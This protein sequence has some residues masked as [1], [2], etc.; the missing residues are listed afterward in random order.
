MPNN[1]DY[2]GSARAAKLRRISAGKGPRPAVRPNIGSMALD[3]QLGQMQCCVYCDQTVQWTP[4]SEN[5]PIR[6]TVS[7]DGSKW[8]YS[9]VYATVTS[10]APFEPL[11]GQLDP[12]PQDT[13]EIKVQVNGNVWTV[14]FVFTQEQNP[15]TFHQVAGFRFNCTN[16]VTLDNTMYY[17]IQ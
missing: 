7:R 8:V 14:Q 12:S 2:S 10:P 17:T 4:S 6:L 15:Y 16:P 1:T 5:N 13:A 3:A 11:F 9:A